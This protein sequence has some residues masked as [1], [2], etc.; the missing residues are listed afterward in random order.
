MPIL[1]RQSRL[2]FRV[3]GGTSAALGA[4]Q[5]ND[6]NSSELTIAERALLEF[7]R[8]VNLNS[9]QIHKYDVDALIESGWNQLQVAEAVHVTAL[10]ATFN[11]VANAFGLASQGLLALYESDLPMPGREDA[12][13]EG[14]EL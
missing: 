13:G 3:Y 9:H 14:T 11:R 7:V 1:R 12:G 10:F 6:L 2:C 4:I 5:A 8:N